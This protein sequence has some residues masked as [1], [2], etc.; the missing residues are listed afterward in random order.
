VQYE[1]ERRVVVQDSG[2]QDL[3]GRMPHDVAV[4]SRGLIRAIA[5]AVVAVFLTG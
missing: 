1:I 5:A 4:L 3:L 2:G